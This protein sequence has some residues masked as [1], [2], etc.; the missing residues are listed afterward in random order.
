MIEV[1]GNDNSKRMAK[2]MCGIEYKNCLYVLY[3]IKRDENNI[4]VFGSKVVK[5]SEGVSVIDSEFSEEEKVWLENISKRI[6]NK[7]SIDNLSSD[8]VKFVKNIDLHDGV[9]K[10]DIKKSYIATM[11]KSAIDVCLM[12]YEIGNNE[13]KSVIKVRENK[14]NRHIKWG[15]VTAIVFGLFV[16]CFCIYL[17]ILIFWK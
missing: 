7:D 1:I 3:L 4:N 14:K 17:L 10:F 2:I 8:G 16:L 5:N 9:N 11:D 15:S 12:Y 13:K 6:F